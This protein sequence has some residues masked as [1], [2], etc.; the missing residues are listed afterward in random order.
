MRVTQLS[1]A[2]LFAACCLNGGQTRAADGHRFYQNIIKESNVDLHMREVDGIREYENEIALKSTV[3]VPTL[4]DELVVAMVDDYMQGAVEKMADVFELREMEIATV[5]RIS[6]PP[7]LLAM[8]PNHFEIGKIPVGPRPSPFA[9]AVALVIAGASD[10]EIHE[11][12]PSLVDDWDARVLKQLEM[13]D[14]LM[15]LREWCW[16]NL[17]IPPFPFPGR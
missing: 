15:E 2:V 11:L 17:P 7:E 16:T 12:L 10:K 8:S 5:A 3:P 6:C 14:A 1:L 4:E 13:T 9:V